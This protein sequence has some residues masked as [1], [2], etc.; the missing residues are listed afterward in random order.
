MRVLVSC[1]VAVALSVVAALPAD[2]TLLRNVRPG[3]I[4]RSAAALATLTRPDGSSR[5]VGA[6]ATPSDKAVATNGGCE[7]L[8]GDGLIVQATEIRKNTSIVLYEGDLGQDA[9]KPYYVANI[10]FAPYAIP[11]TPLNDEIR[12]ACPGKL[13]PFFLSDTSGDLDELDS[14]IATL[15]ASDRET[16]DRLTAG[17]CEAG[18]RC[19]YGAEG[20]AVSEL[21]LDRKWADYVCGQPNFP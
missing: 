12:R 17:K 7:S 5:S 6:S 20:D 21:R 3:V 13:E 15:P 11:H 1:G 2:A 18:W 8:T 9:P 10:D 14:F 19:Q 16:I 4:C